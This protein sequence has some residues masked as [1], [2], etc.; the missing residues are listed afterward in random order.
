M[1][2]MS[3]TVLDF[4]SFSKM[5]GLK[6]DTTVYV[7]VPSS[8]DPKHFGLVYRPIAKM[9]KDAIVTSMPLVI[10]QVK[11]ILAAHPDTKGIIHC[12]NYFVTQE[13][14]KIGN[15][16]LLIQG[17]GKDREKILL[18]HVTSSEPTV[19]VSP[20]MMEGLD[21][22]DDLGRFQ[23]ICKIPFPFLGDP[24]VKKLL[25]KSQRW[26]AWKTALTL[27]QAVGRCVRNE[28][29]WAKTYVLDECFSDLFSR[30]STFFPNS[31]SEMEVDDSAKSVSTVIKPK[32]NK[33]KKRY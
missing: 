32:F 7:D 12:S 18:E 24:V 10:E 2:L 1:L 3:A 22:K 26:Y 28:N 21:L 20:S 9:N 11:K 5:C 6:K 33:W 23:I 31:F 4:E 14:A 27:V 29:D 30:W 15:P 16:R 25:E 17:S 13:I 8:F 19:V